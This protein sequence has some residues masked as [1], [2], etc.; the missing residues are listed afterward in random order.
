MGQK[1]CQKGMSERE[2]ERQ[3]ERERRE[4]NF[5]Q[6]LVDQTMLGHD[7]N[8]RK[9][10]EKLFSLFLLAAL[11]MRTTFLEAPGTGGLEPRWFSILL[12]DLTSRRLSHFNYTLTQI[13][14][15]A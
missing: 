9:E 12:D 11:L 13:K 8:C 15:K 10:G 1:G 3:R 6:L 14:K 7:S 2:R 4:S 5:K